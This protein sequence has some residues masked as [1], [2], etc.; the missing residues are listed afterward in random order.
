MSKQWRHKVSNLQRRLERLEK[1]RGERGA[2]CTWQPPFVEVPA[3]APPDLGAIRAE[4][5]AAGWGPESGRPYVVI[6]EIPAG[7][8]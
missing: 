3:G 6:V 4:A 1:T 5:E 8:R 2:W 7:A